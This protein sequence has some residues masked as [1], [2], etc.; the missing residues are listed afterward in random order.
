MTKRVRTT[1]RLEVWL[2]DTSVALFVLNVQRRLVFFNVGCEQLTG[3]TATDVLGQVCDYVTESDARLPGSLLGSLAAPADVWSGQTITTAVALARRDREPVSCVIHFYPL[4]DAEKKVQ[5]ALGIIRE[6]TTHSKEQITVSKSQLLHAELAQLRHSLKQQFAEG[7]LI[8]RSPGIRR[9]LGQSKLAQKSKVPV[10]LVGE[11][12]T[13]RQHIARQIHCSSDQSENAFVPLDCRRLPADHLA[14]T[15][16]RL[17]GSQHA[18][19]LQCG[20]LYLDRIDALP[21]ELQPLIVDLIESKSPGKPRVMAASSLPLEAFV[22]SD[23]LMSE[24][25]FCLTSLTIFVPALRDRMED[26]EPLAQFFLEELNRG[27]SRQINGFHEDVWQQFRRYHWPGNVNELRAVVTAARRECAGPLIE[28][29]HLPFG[30]RIGVNRQTIGPGTRRRSV[31]LDPLLLRVEREQIELALAEARH[32][33]AK[34]AELLG[35][36]R[37]RLYRRMEI[38]GIVDDENE[39]DSNSS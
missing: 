7:S 10:L 31:P 29:S 12:G 39:T 14:E 11:S 38:L 37:P 27:D 21:R 20:T 1:R 8:G 16:Q 33:K 25:Y 15:L 13:G 28:A 5:A 2:K 36:T 18:E 26:M 30:F 32:N 34:A 3:W 6:A 19:S 17:A 22:E 23:D 35:I 9:I 24:L 4:T